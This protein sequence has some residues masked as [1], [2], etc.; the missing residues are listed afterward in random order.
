MARCKAAKKS[1]KHAAHKMVHAPKFPADHLPA[2]LIHM[3]F[4]YLEPT[5]AAAFRW[6]GRVV[7]EIGLQYLAPTVY[8]KLNEESYNRVLAISEHPVVS[9][10]VINLDYETRGLNA[11][12]REQFDD[13]VI[14][15]ETI[16]QRHESS[17]I[18]NRFA[19]ARAWRAYNRESVRN[20]PLLSRKQTRQLF[21][22]AWSL[23]EAYLASQTMLQRSGFFREKI[24]EAIIRFRNLQ[25]IST[26]ADSAFIR[27]TAQFRD[28]LPTYYLSPLIDNAYEIPPDVGVTSVIMSARQSA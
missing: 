28:F 16:A 3:I 27:Y 13:M 9:K 20:I 24:A 6:A 7:A 4:P 8:L 21:N 15:T 19:S 5:E 14:S 25:R 17:E 2:E 23:Y 10:Y 1:D 22:Q 18:S 11:I 26:S 12:N